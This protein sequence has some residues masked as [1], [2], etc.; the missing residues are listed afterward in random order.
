MMFAIGKRNKFRQVAVTIESDVYFYG[1]FGLA[2]LGPGKDGKAEINNGG[3]KQVEF[4]VELEAMLGCKL[5]AALQQLVK[6]DFIK[7]G[8]LFFIN[9]G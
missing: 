9:S 3:I 8:R 7:C 1:P 6:D 2:E 4:A 5:A